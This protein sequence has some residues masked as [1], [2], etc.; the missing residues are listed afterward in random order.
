MFFIFHFSFFIFFHFSFFFIFFLSFLFIYLIILDV[1]DC[2][3][4][5]L[6]WGR[7]RQSEST[8]IPPK[9]PCELENS[10]AS[11]IMFWEC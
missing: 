2:V 10:V 11:G 7:L 3:V 4:A 6:W 5:G 1:G 9:V 8:R